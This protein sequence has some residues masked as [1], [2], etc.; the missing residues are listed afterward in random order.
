ME[1][2][3]AQKGPLSLQSLRRSSGRK[4]MLRALVYLA[5]LAIN[6]TSF[7]ELKAIHRLLRQASQSSQYTV[8]TLK[9]KEVSY[10]H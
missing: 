5:L 2:H 6:I 9:L 7:L 8:P 4:S 1:F 10:V 3:L